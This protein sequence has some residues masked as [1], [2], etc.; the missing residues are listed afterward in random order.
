MDTKKGNC[1]GLTNYTIHN[2]E[3]LDFA[4]YQNMLKLKD[5][6]KLIIKYSLLLYWMEIKIV[7]LGKDFLINNQD[8]IKLIS[9]ILY[10]IKQHEKQYKTI[11]VGLW[12]NFIL[13]AINYYLFTNLDA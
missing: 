5:K 1:R 9:F 11:F 12:N 3:V 6:S 8:S 2:M 13:N 10:G 4:Y 7:S